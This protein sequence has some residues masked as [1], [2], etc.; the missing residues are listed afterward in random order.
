MCIA[1]ALFALLVLAVGFFAP[2]ELESWE[3]ASLSGSVSEASSSPQ[4]CSLS[5]AFVMLKE[6]SESMC[7]LGALAL[8]MANTLSSLSDKEE[9]MM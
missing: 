8:H 3:S 1:F 2:S 5:L 7:S 9:T 4:T 6:E